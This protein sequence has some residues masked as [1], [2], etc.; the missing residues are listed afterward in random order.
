MTRFA[1]AA[2]F[3]QN[4]MFRNRVAWNLHQGQREICVSLGDLLLEVGDGNFAL[5]GL[6]LRHRQR[7]RVFF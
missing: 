2:S 6:E 7:Q 4:S 1:T 5:L 3:D